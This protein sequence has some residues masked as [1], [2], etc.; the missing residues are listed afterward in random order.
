MAVKVAIN[1]FGRIGRLAFRQLFNQKN[2][3]IVAI[4]D[5]GKVEALAYLLKYDSAHRSWNAD[6]I[7]ADAS[8]N[9]ITVAGK[10]IKVCKETDPKLLPW[11]ELGVD[12]VIESTGRFTE[13][14]KAQAHID[15]GAKKVVISAPAKGDLK[16]I[17]YNV[18][19]KTLNKNDT[20]ISAASCTTNCLAPVVNV[21]ENEYGIVKGWMTTIHAATNDQRLLDLEH[22]D[23]RRGRSALANIV[24]ASTGAAAA[25]GLVI[26]DVKGKLDGTAMRVPLITGSI[27]DLTIELK[28]NVTVEEINTLMKKHA[29]E[30]L[31]YTEDPIVSTDI[32]G[33]SFGSIFDATLTKVMTINGKQIVKVFSWYDNEMSYVSQL[34][35]TV[36]YFAQL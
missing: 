6:K 30:S 16:T 5:L 24:P 19:H 4:N 17:V 36:L 14:D 25:I 7:K 26:P 31:G 23:F 12:V 34:V 15:A 21:L 11:K 18:N 33:S 2:I 35:R 22:S 1:G 3:E 29:N 13:K 27:V 20:I 9:I 32:I 28:K 10:T 8:K